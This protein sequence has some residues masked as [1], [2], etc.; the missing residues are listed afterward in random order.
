M[1]PQSGL[2]ITESFEAFNLRVRR[3]VRTKP[4]APGSPYGGFDGINW[5][6]DEKDLPGVSLR[7]GLVGP[8]DLEKVIEYWHRD[9]LPNVPGTR[10]VMLSFPPYDAEPPPGFHFL[11]YDC[12]QWETEGRHFSIIC[13]DLLRDRDPALKPY[14]TALNQHQ[15]FESVATAADALA[16]RQRIASRYA[17]G[18]AFE[19]LTIYGVG[20]VGPIGISEFHG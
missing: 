2:L 19:D 8:A 17:P 6:P 4:Q 3:A 12:G 1:E 13:N 5:Q 18:T 20:F 15:L 14:C 10:L 16:E 9:V 7:L 11:G